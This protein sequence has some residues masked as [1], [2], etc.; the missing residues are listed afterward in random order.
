MLQRRSNS[1]RTLRSGR[2]RASCRLPDRGGRQSAAARIV[3]AAIAEQLLRA[4]DI[5]AEV[6]K[7][8]GI[9]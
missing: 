9:V 7:P 3:S 1:Q 2:L 6:A 5:L 8:L 4:A